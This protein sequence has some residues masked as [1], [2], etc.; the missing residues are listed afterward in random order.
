[1]RES[2]LGMWNNRKII[3]ELEKSSITEKGHSV[4]QVGSGIA[5]GESDGHGYLRNSRQVDVRSYLT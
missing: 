2:G 5:R 1:M 3:D 4:L